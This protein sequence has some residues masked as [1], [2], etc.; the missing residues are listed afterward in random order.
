MC[1]QWSLWPLRKSWPHFSSGSYTCSNHSWLKMAM[2]SAIEQF[3]EIAFQ[4]KDS[5]PC[6]DFLSEK[7]ANDK[8]V[9]MFW[10]KIISIL[11][12]W[13]SWSRFTIFSIIV[14]HWSQKQWPGHSAKT[15]LKVLQ[16]IHTDCVW[17]NRESDLNISLSLTS[18]KQ[19]PCINTSQHTWI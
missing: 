1:S 2:Q 5:L 6:F 17:E 7:V 9:I 19:C 8:P 4:L 15:Q 14:R 12:S 18:I 3:K 16:D 13:K 10:L 11:S